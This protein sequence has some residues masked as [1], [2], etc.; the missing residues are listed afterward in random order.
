M[1]TQKRGIPDNRV[2]LHI[3]LLVEL[4]VTK[5]S[6]ICTL[7]SNKLVGD[8]FTIYL[9]SLYV[10]IRLYSAVFGKFGG[11]SGGRCSRR[12]SGTDKTRG[13]HPMPRVDD[14]V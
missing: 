10:A 3:L 1:K 7:Y 4:T 2:C 5:Y 6:S 11:L 9:C 12:D 13:P 8:L 14:A